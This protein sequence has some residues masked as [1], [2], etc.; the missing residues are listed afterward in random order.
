MPRTLL[1]NTPV[2]KK[3]ANQTAEIIAGVVRWKTIK[4]LRYLAL[5]AYPGEKN[6]KMS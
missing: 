1:K 6:R 4:Y 2:L 5:L 3:T